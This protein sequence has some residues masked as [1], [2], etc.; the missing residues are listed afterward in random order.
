MLVLQY[1]NS[2]ESS[3]SGDDK[4]AGS[5][6]SVQLEALPQP[7]SGSCKGKECIPDSPVPHPLALPM[8]A[9]IVPPQ[10]PLFKSTPRATAGL[11]IVTS[12]VTSSL[13]RQLRLNAERE[14]DRIGMLLEEERS[15]GAARDKCLERLVQHANRH[16]TQLKQMDG[17]LQGME[18]SQ[19]A[20]TGTPGSVLESPIS[21][22]F[23]PL[24]G[25]ATS[26]VPSIPGTPSV[27]GSVGL[28]VGTP[29][30]LAG[31]VFKP[32]GNMAGWQ[33]ENPVKNFF[34]ES[35]Y[36]FIGTTKSDPAPPPYTFPDGCADY[37]PVECM[38]SGL[39]VGQ[40]HWDKA[41]KDQLAWWPLLYQPILSTIPADDPTFAAAVRRFP[42]HVALKHTPGEIETMKKLA[43]GRQQKID[44]TRAWGDYVSD[45]DTDQEQ[46]DRCLNVLQP[47]SRAAWLVNI[48]FACVMAKSGMNVH[49]LPQSNQA[50]PRLAIT[51]PGA[52]PT[53]RRSNGPEIIAKIPICAFNRAWL[54]KTSNE[55]ELKVGSNMVDWHIVD[56]PDIS[57][58]V[59]TYPPITKLDDGEDLDNGEVEG[60]QVKGWEGKSEILGLGFQTNQMINNIP[61]EP[62]LVDVQIVP[63]P[64]LSPIPPPSNHSTS[65]N[66]Q[67][68]IPSKPIPPHPA[69]P[70]N[71]DN[72]PIPPPCERYLP[73]NNVLH[74]L[75]PFSLAADLHAPA[76]EPVFDHGVPSGSTNQPMVN[77]DNS[78]LPAIGG[79]VVAPPKS[80]PG[81]KGKRKVP[82]VEQLVGEDEGEGEGEG[83]TTQRLA[84]RRLTHKQPAVNM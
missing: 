32:K 48:F 5:K 36:G 77:Q 8:A 11:Q 60:E 19:E 38:Q 21:A 62:S 28:P 7:V 4:K 65:T 72:L 12:G 2:P 74:S 33:V 10:A 84:M 52:V 63:P 24:P 69:I 78:S 15:E 9:H 49:G 41:M 30:V 68:S 46:E 64:L 18:D 22:T 39:Y 67:G 83:S 45:K 3:S 40:P 27:A 35:F 73:P 79:S 25:S 44:S 76:S 29:L 23:P 42:E 20:C 80:K 82:E 16:D 37:F 66:Q 26:I 13:S 1:S 70:P 43:Q 59:D 50:R 34:L 55:Q 17:R 58:F 14:V 57:N 6:D 81:Q 56:R 51:A 61:L 71:N 53:L 54:K 75:P 47:A 31:A